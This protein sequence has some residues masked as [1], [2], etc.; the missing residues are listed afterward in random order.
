VADLV[1]VGDGACNVFLGVM[2]VTRIE[3]GETVKKPLLM[4]LLLLVCLS[5]SAGNKKNKL[6]PTD[7]QKRQA[8]ISSPDH[9]I[10]PNRRIGPI[11]LGM[12]QDQVLAILGQPDFD[13]PARGYGSS[14]Q[15]Y[16]DS[17]NLIIYF[18]TDAAPAV[19]MI[20]AQGFTKGARTLGKTD[21]KNIQPIETNWSASAGVQLGSSSFEVKRAYSA[22]GYEDTGGIMMNYKG[23]G[24]SFILTM[25]HMVS[26][27][28]VSAPQ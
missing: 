9:Q 3:K 5:A 10:A 1:F 13:V 17:L 15:Y 20:T 28:S 8:V 21:W 27:I 24:I 6:S 16:Y 14:P 22:Y 11:S 18:T 7:L 4:V 26:S 25:D 12:G 19:S 2:E 23:L